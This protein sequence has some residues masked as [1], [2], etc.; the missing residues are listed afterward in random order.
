M[1]LLN[2]NTIVF[3][4]L[5]VRAGLIRKNRSNKNIVDRVDFL[6][7]DTVSIFKN[8]LQSNTELLILNQ[9]QIE[10]FNNI[11]RNDVDFN[12]D[13]ELVIGLTK[14]VKS[15]QINSNSFIANSIKK[16][17]STLQLEKIVEIFVEKMDQVFEINGVIYKFFDFITYNKELKTLTVRMS[18]KYYNLLKNEANVVVSL[19]DYHKTPSAEYKSL[20]LLL[21]ACAIHNKKQFISKSKIIEI[22]D[23][24]AKNT[25]T[26]MKNLTELL[27]KAECFE[28]EKSYS[29]VEKENRYAFTNKNGYKVYRTFFNFTLKAKEKLVKSTKIVNEYALNIVNNTK[30]TVKQKINKL[31]KRLHTLFINNQTDEA[32][33]VAEYIN[34]LKL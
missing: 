22:L 23:I 7:K 8:T 3:N 4:K 30:N 14:S 21:N 6:S 24:T 15:G 11:N 9:L 25:R 20:L 1:L 12:I 16:N 31:S 2:S 26:I 5:L 19:D 29:T 33:I 13:N 34:Q 17:Y 10:I 18:E 27:Q 28:V 32:L